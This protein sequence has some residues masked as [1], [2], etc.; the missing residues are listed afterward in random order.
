MADF[1]QNLRMS[2]IFSNPIGEPNLSAGGID[3]GTV[4]NA[5]APF[6]QQ[7]RDRNRNAVEMF[8]GHPNIPVNT[9]HSNYLATQ[10]DNVQLGGEIP[11]TSPTGMPLPQEEQ[12]NWAKQQADDKQMLALLGLQQKGDELA[13]KGEI[14]KG[15]LGV[16]QQLADI[17]KFKAENPNL[18]VIEA[19][20][21]ILGVNP[22]SG[23]T[24]KDFGSSGK[25][26]D[27]QKLEIQKQNA[28]D[29]IAAR[30]DQARLT[31]SNKPATAIS[32]E[33]RKAD[34]SNKYDI[35]KNTRPDLAQFISIDPTTN[36]PM[37]DPSNAT[38]EQLNELTNLIY[39]R[40]SDIN[41]PSESKSNTTKKTNTN[42]TVTI[43]DGKGNNF[44]INKNQLQDAISKGYKQV[45][46]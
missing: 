40:S 33:Q 43:T 37:I 19:N 42:G 13:Q 15:E 20:G 44:S 30:G 8:G 17:Q 32:P 26:S 2:N 28:L 1:L 7:I 27:A 34:I 25:L 4:N 11:A 38:Q 9:M 10:P 45:G 46:Q 29:E 36:K 31:Q 39:G 35:I 5:I 18:K 16:K 23:E 24:V 41:L 21:K 6:L 14:A 12:M 22:F 3:F